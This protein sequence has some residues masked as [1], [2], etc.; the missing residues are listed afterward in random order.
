MFVRSGKRSG[1]IISP[2]I[3]VVYLIYLFVL[4][5]YLILKAE[6]TLLQIY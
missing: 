4:T 1:A 3:L 6:Q 2:L 5:L